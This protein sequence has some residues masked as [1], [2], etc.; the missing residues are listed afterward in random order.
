MALAKPCQHGHPKGI[1]RLRL[2]P[3]EANGKREERSQN[4]HALHPCTASPQG[5]NGYACKAIQPPRRLCIAL[6]CSI[7]RRD[8]EQHHRLED[9]LS[10]AGI[11]PALGA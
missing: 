8:G 9:R 5:F 10:P 11:E 2:I 4:T 7:G 3:T 1:K 6:P